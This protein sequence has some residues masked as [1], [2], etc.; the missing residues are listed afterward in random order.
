MKKGSIVEDLEG[1]K[2]LV[3][4]VNNGVAT[5]AIHSPIA[6]GLVAVTVPVDDLREIE[7]PSDGIDVFINEPGEQDYI[8]ETDYVGPAGFGML[9]RTWALREEGRGFIDH[10]NTATA[11]YTFG[12]PPEIL[13][14]TDN[15]YWK[16]VIPGTGIFFVAGSKEAA[17]RGV[18]GELSKALSRRNIRDIICSMFD[19]REHKNI[20]AKEY[21]IRII[22][23]IVPMIVGVI[24]GIL[25]VMAMKL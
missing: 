8:H 24:A 17:I 1:T 2:M 4:E 13:L 19:A 23:K 20:S 25:A 12:D 18:K 11:K 7:P 14:Y 5:C 15:I 21:T 6:S 10:I 3:I 22:W 9:D 16:S